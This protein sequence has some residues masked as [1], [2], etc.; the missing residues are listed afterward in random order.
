MD[1]NPR[2][3]PPPRF[4]VMTGA[5]AQARRQVSVNMYAADTDD[6]QQ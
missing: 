5:A 1:H 6:A 4:A 3:P 2:Q